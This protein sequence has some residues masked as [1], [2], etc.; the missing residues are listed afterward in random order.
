MS[1]T[2]VTYSL[3]LNSNVRAAIQAHEKDALRLDNVMH[4]LN[5]TMRMFGLGFA[6]HAALAGAK[7]WIHT[8]AE[9]EQNLIR[10]KNL[11]ENPLEG[12]KN[13][14][15]INKEV[16]KFKIGVQEAVE[17]YGDFLAMVKGA[18]LHPE[19][20]RKLHDEILMIGKV[21]ALPDNQMNGA[22]R[23]LGKMLEVGGMDARHF[24]FFEQQLSGIGAYVA[25]EMGVSLSELARMRHE[26]ELTTKDPKIL[27]DAI[28]KM[29][30]D[31]EK[32]LPESLNSTSSSINE[33]SNE[34]IRFKTEFVLHNKEDLIDFFHS[35]Q[36]GISFLSRHKEGLSRSLK[37]VIHIAEAYVGYKVVLGAINLTQS[38]FITKTIAQASAYGVQAAS[39]NTLV[40]AIERLNFVQNAQNAS[41]LTNAA[42]MTMANTV[43]NRYA[44][45]AGSAAAASA[46]GAAASGGI[47]RF[48]AGAMPVFIAGMAVQVANDL[49]NFTGKSPEEFG[50]FQPNVLEMLLNPKQSGEKIGKEQAAHNF[51]QKKL[52]EYTGMADVANSSK[53][54]NPNYILSEIQKLKLDP[55]GHD[56]NVAIERAQ[57]IF[58]QM[59]GSINILD[60]LNPKN[61][62]GERLST[63]EQL[64][65]IL[66]RFGYKTPYL[67]YNETSHDGK[68]HFDANDLKSSHK[69]KGNSITNI[70][71]EIKEMNGIKQAT[72][73]TNGSTDANK[74]AEMVGIALTKQLTEVVNDSQIVGQK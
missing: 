61:N 27:L 19:K 54:K 55:Q 56:L 63:N 37:A 73:Q 3:Y 58:N 2:S 49:F 45:T 48:V 44:M 16:D 18:E 43:G 20:V 52:F 66:D 14:R 10:I 57:K 23:N 39:V 7:E 47:G 42:G 11:S 65:P 32:K 70:N 24:F 15:F 64:K 25:R 51:L 6:G 38:L 68:S 60:A 46:G 28:A 5:N 9:L 34:W 59:G 8:A 30:S 67:K 71:I 50:G 36:N 22:V 4:G 31:F 74:I 35:L 26:G 1:S 40:A 33:L 72:I 29:S 62:H 13:Q 53:T 17:G 12:F 41:F 21:M 69:L